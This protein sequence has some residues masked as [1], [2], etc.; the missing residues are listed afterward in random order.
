MESR[1][2]NWNASDDEPDEL[3]EPDDGSGASTGW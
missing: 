2:T 3:D 1:W